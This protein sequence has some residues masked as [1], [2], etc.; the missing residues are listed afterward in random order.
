MLSRGVQIV[1]CK[2]SKSAGSAD[3]RGDVWGEGV[4]N[5]EVIQKKY[6]DIKKKVVY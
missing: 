4:I 3:R 6:N 2:S 1:L 5:R